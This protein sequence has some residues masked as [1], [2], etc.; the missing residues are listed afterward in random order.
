MNNPLGIAFAGAG[1]IASTH[2]LASLDFS[3]IKVVAMASNNPAAAKRRAKL[4]NVAPYAFAELEAMCGRKDVDVVFIQGPNYL[5]LQHSLTAIK[6]GKHIVIEKPMAMTLQEADAIIAAAAKAGVVIGYAENH[7]FSSPLIKARELVAAGEI[8]NVH[9]IKAASA[10]GGR[11]MCWFWDPTLSGGGVII[12]LV[13]HVLSGALYLLDKPEV[14]R[15][16]AASMLQSAIGDIDSLTEVKVETAGGIIIDLKGSWEAPPDEEFYEISGTRGT[17]KVTNTLPHWI[18]L[19]SPEGVSRDIDFP[20]RLNFNLRKFI[21]NNG[22]NTQ[23]KHFADCFR[24]GVTPRQTGQDGRDILAIL[25]AA[26]LS[27]NR[28]Q[29]VALMDAIPTDRTAHQ[30][31]RGDY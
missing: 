19:V 3:D 18:S 16:A 17:L 31:W 26:A 23:M 6:A 14:L 8:G 2:M 5:R 12:N 11:E 29:P 24:Q 27:A 9:T 1:Y 10:H 15:V 30:L 22:Y 20:G 21:A 7:A 28:K 13:P 4:F 25:L